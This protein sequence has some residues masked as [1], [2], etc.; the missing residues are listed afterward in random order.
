MKIVLFGPPGAGKGTQAVRLTE[1][2]AI[3]HISTGDMFRAAIQQG[4]PTGLEAKS[5]MDRGEL[6]PDEVTTRIVAE[7]IAKP[8]CQNGFILDGFP[9]TV[10]QAQALADIAE[11]DVVVNFVAD[12][13]ALVRRLGGRRSCPTHGIYHI[14]WISGDK[15][16]CPECGETL[17]KRADDEETTIRNRLT[18]YHAQTA[19]VVDYYQRK[20]V[21]K[22]VDGMLSVADTYKIVTELLGVAP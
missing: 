14:D 16:H 19:P 20:G 15:V 22:E 2:M 6:V 17:V 8:D 12:D 10:A 13:E 1:R 3:P 7:R 21:L 18:V 9:R 11:I 4:T 5:Y